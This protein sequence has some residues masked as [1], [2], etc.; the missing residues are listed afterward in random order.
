MQPMERLHDFSLRTSGSDLD[1][2]TLAN[3]IADRRADPLAHLDPERSSDGG[4][5]TDANLCAVDTAADDR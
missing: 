1:P 5:H 2:L 4:A 3:T